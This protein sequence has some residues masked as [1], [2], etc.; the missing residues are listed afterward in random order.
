M[1]IPYFLKRDFLNPEELQEVLCDLE[2]L[3]SPQ[4]LLPGDKTHSAKDSEGNIF[5]QNK[6]IFL[7]QSHMGLAPMLF[8]TTVTSKKVLG[9]LNEFC[10]LSPVNRALKAGAI[11]NGMLLSYYENSDYYAEHIDA[12]L[13]TVLIWFW[14]EPKRFTGGNFKFG[15]TGE[16]IECRNNSILIF[17]SW[18]LHSVDPVIIDPQYQNQKLGR[19]CV[20]LFIHPYQPDHKGLFQDLVQTPK[21]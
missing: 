15:D 6:G 21:K 1:E 19:Y 14:K 4:L 8:R 13:A 18:A 17:P 20:S 9:Y 3:N 12:A 10:T 11:I 2:R 7:E 16:V 5:K